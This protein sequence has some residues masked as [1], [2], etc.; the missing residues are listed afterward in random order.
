METVAPTREKRRGC[1]WL[2]WT[3]GVLLALPFV[4]F[5]LSNLLLCSPWGRG[6][7]ERKIQALTGQEAY[8]GSASWSPWN[9]ASLYSVKI[10]QPQ[11][12]R[13][14]IQQPMVSAERL[15][16]VPVWK[17]WLR[18]KRSISSITME[19]PR[20]VLAIEAISS[21]IKVPGESGIP[22][23]AQASASFAEGPP[24]LNPPVGTTPRGPDIRIASSTI[25]DFP[26]DERTPQI[27]GIP[28]S[29]LNVRTASLQLVS[30]QAGKSL[31]EVS[32]I[33]GRIPFSGDPATSSLQV[34]KLA[35]MEQAQP[36]PLKLEFSWNLPVL[37]LSR[38]EIPLGKQKVIFAAKLAKRP[39]IPMEWQLQ[40]PL[41]P[42]VKIPLPRAT[43]IEAESVRFQGRFL[44]ALTAPATWS[45]DFL[46]E[47]KGLHGTLGGREFSFDKGQALTF[48]RGHILSCLDARLVGEEISL[49]GNATLLADGRAAGV[50]RF[51]ATPESIQAITNHFFPGISPPPVTSPLGT[52]QRVA[53][54][55][56][57]F[58][59]IG[60]MYLQLGQDGPLVRM[61]ATPSSP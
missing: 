18:G 26:P 46:A 53:F 16:I 22:A 29:W 37:A 61:N 54:D 28:T 41:Q 9:G 44:G 32:H 6:R 10:L 42:L 57:T 49:L 25:P 8:I 52:P 40:V 12:L 15:N 20:L 31:L 7:I 14:Y 50:M 33:S 1:R 38:L 24:P 3:A 35:V 59:R 47:V 39:G 17:S 56:H 5:A 58:G 2:L 48:L 34:G 13:P 51:V 36:Q 19:S 11:P 4:I 23:P 21:A 30:A 45:G 27:T 43:Q 60:D 55:L